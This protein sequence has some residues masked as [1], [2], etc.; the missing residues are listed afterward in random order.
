MNKTKERTKY[1]LILLMCAFTY[2]FSVPLL[3]LWGS[4]IPTFMSVTFMYFGATVAIFLIYIYKKLFTKTFKNKPFEKKEKPMMLFIILADALSSIFLV[5]GL[6]LV[7]AETSSL[8]LSF[9]IVVVAVIAV[10]FLKEKL[11]LLGWIGLGLIVA[12]GISLSLNEHG[13]SFDVN[14]IFILVPCI[15]WGVQTDMIKKISGQDPVKICLIKTTG[16]AFVDLIFACVMGESIAVS[17]I[18][19]SINILFLGFLTYGLAVC[20]MLVCQRHLGASVTSCY[21][22]LSPFI[23]SIYSLFVFHTVP[24]FT[25]YIAAGLNVLGISLVTINEYLPRI[26]NWIKLKKSPQ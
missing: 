2:A 20:I 26:K 6:T 7:S 5:Y 21:F 13:I 22:G 9:Q 18:P 25:F 10:I 16:S 14:A 11:G 23:G 19:N 3:S 8:L 17:N 15:L 1:I 4:S 24:Y 12:G